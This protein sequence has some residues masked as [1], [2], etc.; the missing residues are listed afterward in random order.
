VTQPQ[1]NDVNVDLLPH[2]SELYNHLT[3]DVDVASTTIDVTKALVYGR[4]DDVSKDDVAA[5]G[6]H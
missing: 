5:D 6:I 2:T 1:C 4:P 3:I